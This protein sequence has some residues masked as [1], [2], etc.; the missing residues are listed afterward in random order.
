MEAPERGEG[1]PEAVGLHGKAA[2][3]ALQS[4]A[5]RV[6]RE[7]QAGK[8]PPSQGSHGS[9][10]LPCPSRGQPPSHDQEGHRRG[11]TYGGVD[12]MSKSSHAPPV[13]PDPK[14]STICLQRS[15]FCPVLT[16]FHDM[17]QCLLETSR[18][19]GSGS[20]R[21]PCCSP[22]TPSHADTPQPHQDP[23]SYRLAAQGVGFFPEHRMAIFP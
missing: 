9:L 21:K 12:S 20:E 3:E 14:D 8:S 17:G 1:C 18:L 10:P 4:G 7:L 22:A 5:E 6:R 19:G 13:S 23:A 15:V 11:P 16:C 2:A